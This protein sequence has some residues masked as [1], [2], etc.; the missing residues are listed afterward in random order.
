MY[1]QDTH[2]HVLEVYMMY[3]M[4]N[5]GIH[6]R[7]YNHVFLYTCVQTLE[8]E[9]ENLKRDHTGLMQEHE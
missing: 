7:R 1:G 3:T 2:V 9:V 6:V 8:E 5:I 4:H